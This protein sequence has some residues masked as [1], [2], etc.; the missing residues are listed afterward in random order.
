[1][2][3]KLIFLCSIL[4][5]FFDRIQLKT[6]KSTISCTIQAKLLFPWRFCVN[7][8]ISLTEIYYFPDD[9]SLKLLFLVRKVLFLWRFDYTTIS[10]SVRYASPIKTYKR[11]H[12][13]RPSTHTRDTG[14]LLLSSF[15]FPATEGAIAPAV[16]KEKP[17][18]GG[19]TNGNLVKTTISLTILLLIGRTHNPP[20]LRL[21]PC[22]SFIS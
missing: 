3:L 11:R 10:L 14:C 20:S 15:S 16:G 13:K 12:I 1:M 6:F 4:W 2:F 8:T 22:C 18:W 21:H 7:I 9:F 5:L 19:G 17:G